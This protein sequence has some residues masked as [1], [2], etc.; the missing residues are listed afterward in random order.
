MSNN[1]QDNQEI[2]SKILKVL[3]DQDL[4]VFTDDPLENDMVLNMGP[5]H[6]STHGVLRI[7]IRLDGET[8][9]GKN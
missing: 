9:T 4:H 1:I 7:L 8:S 2:K 5:S 3:L 6:P